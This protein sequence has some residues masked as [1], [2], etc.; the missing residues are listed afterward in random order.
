MLDFVG[1]HPAVTQVFIDATPADEDRPNE[2]RAASQVCTGAADRQPYWDS[3][4]RF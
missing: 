1:I 3:D 2:Q 4:H